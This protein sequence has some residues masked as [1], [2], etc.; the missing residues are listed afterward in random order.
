MA[1]QRYTSEID[2]VAG[3]F[4][5]PESATDLQA[6][7]HACPACRATLK[8]RKLL[9]ASI[10]DGLR[11]RVNDDLSAAFPT[12]V[13]ARINAE[14]GPSLRRLWLIGGLV[15]TAAALVIAFVLASGHWT[16][17]ENWHRTQI[18]REV[19]PQGRAPLPLENKNLTTHVPAASQTARHFVRLHQLPRQGM[20]VVA[21][22]AIPEV[23][24]PAEQKEMMADLLDSLRNG[25]VQGEA[26]LSEKREIA[27][28]PIQIALLSDFVAPQ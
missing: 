22:V 14:A 8:T 23:L 27:L 17:G 20:R 25:N 5:N 12:G 6:H 26:L 28:P 7:L 13:R 15:A 19:L 2:D 18:A 9:Y 1:C 21:R 4:S 24:V 16:G 10:D 3:G 11:V